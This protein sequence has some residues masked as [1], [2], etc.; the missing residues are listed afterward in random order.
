[1]HKKLICWLLNYV[2]LV[3]WSNCDFFLKNSRD[4]IFC[5]KISL[6]WESHHQKTESSTNF[7]HKFFGSKIGK[8]RATLAFTSKRLHNRWKNSCYPNF[9]SEILLNCQKNAFPRKK[10]TNPN[11]SIDSSHISFMLS[12]AKSEKKIGRPHF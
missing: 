10:L 11:I 2:N 6:L 9:Y 7:H 5:R 12:H 4:P 3:M 1:M 8:I